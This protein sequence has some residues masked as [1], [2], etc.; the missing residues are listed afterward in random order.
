MYTHVWCCIYDIEDGKCETV[1]L[2]GK[3]MDITRLEEFREEVSDLLGKAMYGKVTGKEYG[4]IKD[5]CA[6]RN[7]I[8]YA[9]CL[10][11]GM[12]EDRAAYAFFD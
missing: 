1:N 5:I 12:S 11:S 6:E 10:A 4:R 9:T 7:L 3:E 2:M 8:R